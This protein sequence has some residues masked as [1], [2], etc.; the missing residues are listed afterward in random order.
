MD[1]ILVDAFALYDRPELLAMRS[2]MGGAVLVA[3]G[4][5][6]A[7]RGWARAALLLGEANLSLECAPLRRSMIEHAAALHWL[8]DAPEDVMATLKKAQQATVA[9]IEEAMGEGWSVPAEIFRE[10]LD[11]PVEGSKEDTNLHFTNRMRRDDQPNL[12]VAWLAETMVSHPSLSS[13]SPYLGTPQEPRV[14]VGALAAA[15]SDSN[16]TQVALLLL[17]ASG[18]FNRFLEGHPW[19][20]ALERMEARFGEAVHRQQPAD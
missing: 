1:Q 3:H 11:P 16:K 19:A 12:L 15:S 20:E 13:A 14:A 5:Y 18:G 17:L 10:I 6:S 8:A 4:W 7:V 9:K 2:D